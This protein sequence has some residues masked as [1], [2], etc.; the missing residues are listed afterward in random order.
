MGLYC[1]VNVG[2]VGFVIEAGL[3]AWRVECPTI[4]DGKP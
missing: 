4:G 3:N 1:A 2:F